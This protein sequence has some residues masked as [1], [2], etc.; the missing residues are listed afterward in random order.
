[1]IQ[2]ITWFKWIEVPTT[3]DKL[4]F[5]HLRYG[6]IEYDLILQNHNKWLEQYFGI[7]IRSL[8]WEP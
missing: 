4:L 7:N 6:E 5:N 8:Q 3:I 1:M 2:H